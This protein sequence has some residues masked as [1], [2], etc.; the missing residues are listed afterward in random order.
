MTA[1][2]LKRVRNIMGVG[3]LNRSHTG[4][5]RCYLANIQVSSTP[6]PLL[7]NTDRMSPL[8]SARAR[9]GP[10]VVI[11][12][13]PGTAY[14]VPA[15]RPPRDLGISGCLSE[16]LDEMFGPSCVSK[17]PENRIWQLPS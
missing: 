17:I 5:T 10:I 13:H 9:G 3:P 14:R 12:E 2:D 1:Y 11:P 4:M 8:S 6:R 15:D 16:F 7:E